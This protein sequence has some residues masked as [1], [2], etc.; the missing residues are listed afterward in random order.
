M[1]FR[2]I[3]I[4]TSIGLFASVVAVLLT[5]NEHI[6]FY[7]EQHHLFLY[8]W[9]YT[10]HEIHQE[11][12]LTW[13]G[14][15]II[16]FY[17]IP[18]LGASIVGLMMVGVYLLTESIIRKL[19]GLRDFLQLGVALAMVLYFT[20]NQV[21]TTPGLFV[22]VFLCLAALRLI[23]LAVPKLPWT[24]NAVSDKEKMKPLHFIIPLVFAAAYIGGSYIKAVKAFEPHERA[25][26]MA[27]KATKEKDWD[28]V[29]ELTDSYLT[30]RP[31]NKLMIYLRCLALANRGI[32][33]EK[34]LDFPMKQ[35][36][37]AIVFP[38]DGDS[39][40]AEVGHWVNEYTG[41]INDATHWAFE[42]LSIWGE[43]P[44]N[45]M[46]LAKYNIALGKP[47][48][49]QKFVNK[50]KHSLFYRKEAASL[51]RQIYG[52]EPPE[53][54]YSFATDSIGSSRFID[55]NAARNL[56]QNVEC[57]P[58]N[59]IARQYFLASLILANDQDALIANL[60]PGKKYPP[61]VEQ[62]MLI[63]TLYPDSTPLEELGLSIS[64]KCKDS[65]GRYSDMVRKNQTLNEKEMFGNS[66]WYY[67]G[68][69]CPYGLRKRSTLKTPETLS[70][71]ELKH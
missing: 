32:L 56:Q 68:R 15:F 34:L 27:D 10:V 60:E 61:V 17:H 64:Q 66:F 41:S 2:L 12:F 71:M 47:K 69:L 21:D 7:E 51:Q 29:I 16:Q 24:K 3:K 20:F 59:D 45:L 19:T 58:D 9:D 5:L 67:I 37:D 39:R 6:L 70:G 23:L 26:I 44:P 63:Y 54:R 38:W 25:M 13:L 55:F 46:N 49:A 11:G 22:C 33:L 53:V 31:N 8:T 50:L 1:N 30:I 14:A 28:K 42:S 18:W 40:L 48:V 35:G 62:A 43:T 52:M 4:L 57:D 65:Y 36:V